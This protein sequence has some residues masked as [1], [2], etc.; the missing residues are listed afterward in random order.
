MHRHTPFGGHN[1]RSADT[2]NDSAVSKGR[3]TIGLALGGGAARGFAHIGVIRTL[4]AKGLKPDVICGTS[5]GAVVGGA[6]AADRL[7]VL[8]AWAR[9]PNRCTT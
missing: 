5:I 8:E 1:A 7:D 2:D 4:A 9:S 3:P 6:I